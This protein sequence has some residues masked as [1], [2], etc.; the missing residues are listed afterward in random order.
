MEKWFIESNFFKP[1]NSSMTFADVVKNNVC[2]SK[3]DKNVPLVAVQGR[4]QQRKPPELVK[5]VSGNTQAPH[6]TLEKENRLVTKP[7]V[8]DPPH[9]PIPCFN[10]FAPLIDTEH[11][12]CIDN[13]DICKQFN[14]DD[15]YGFAAQGPGADSPAEKLPIDRNDNF[16]TLL[17][18]KKL[19]KE[20]I[21]QAQACKDYQ[22]CKNQM[23]VPFGVI[24]LSPLLVYT[25]PTICNK[26]VSDPLLAHKLVRQSGRPKFLGSCIP[27]HSKLN[28]QN[29][30]H[31]LQ[32]FGDKQLVDL[33]EYSF[34]LDFDRDTPLLSTEENHAS[35]KN[36][37]KGCLHL[38][39]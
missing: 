5:E 9:D 16:D 36:F 24:P 6:L 37:Y 12:L 11:E 10:K 35:A 39:Y 34:P 22:A 28:I 21:S 23:E 8:A 20:I 26:S 3:K 18:K 27:V 38:Y 32:D 25:G 19:D 30:R 13:M 15:D 2:M 1:V 7:V 31:Y 29:W 33:L 14:T 17:V 4:S